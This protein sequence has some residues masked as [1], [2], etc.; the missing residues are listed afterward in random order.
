MAKLTAPPVIE[1]TEEVVASMEST[2]GLP[3][4]PPVAVGE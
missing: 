1:Q 4:A 3:E 2:T